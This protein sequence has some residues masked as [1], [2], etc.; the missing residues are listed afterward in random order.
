MPGFEGEWFDRIRRH[1][2]GASR[3]PLLDNFVGLLEWLAENDPD[4]MLGMMRENLGLTIGVDFR[5]RQRLLSK[6]SGGHD[7]P[8]WKAFFTAGVLEGRYPSAHDQYRAILTAAEATGDRLLAVQTLAQL[9]ICEMLMNRF[10]EAEQYARRCL[11]IA[12]APGTAAMVP[13][14][15]QINGMVLIHGG[16]PAEGFPL[17]ER[18]EQL[19]PVS[20]DSAI[21]QGLRAFYLATYGRL[22]EADRC[23]ETPRK[24]ATDTGHASLKIVC[25]LAEALILA[26]D[27]AALDSI[28]RLKRLARLAAFHQ[29]SRHTVVTNEELA[30]AY[31]RTG[32]TQLARERAVEARKLRM[33]KAMAYTPWDRMRLTKTP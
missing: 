6:T 22:T 15:T 20:L 7:L 26:N 19:Y 11:S 9:C 2:S 8:G 21:I 25:G 23:L 14:A 1:R 27:T 4:R 17:L 5:D 29:D 18:A 33:S 31:L 10:S 16:R 12:A 32:E 24:V 3:P 28:D 13:T 30:K